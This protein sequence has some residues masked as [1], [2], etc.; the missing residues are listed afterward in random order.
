MMHA[1]PARLSRITALGVVESSSSTTGVTEYAFV[2]LAGN[3]IS[4][5]SNTAAQFPRKEE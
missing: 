1:I 2:G 4:T 5:V 3:V